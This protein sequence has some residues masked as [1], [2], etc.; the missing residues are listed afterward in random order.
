MG[1]QEEVCFS[2]NKNPEEGALVGD[3]STTTS[4]AGLAC[5]VNSYVS[6]KVV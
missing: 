6:L 5:D 4:I 2:W 1:G 3:K